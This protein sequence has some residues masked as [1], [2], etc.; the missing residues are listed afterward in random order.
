MRMPLQKKGTGKLSPDPVDFQIALEN[1][2]GRAYTEYVN[3]VTLTL[4][5]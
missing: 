3:S 5:T 2:Q 4:S 1:P